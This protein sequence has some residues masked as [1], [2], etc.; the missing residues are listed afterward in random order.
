MSE[1]VEEDE[2]NVCESCGTDYLVNLRVPDCVW[3][4][5]KPEDHPPGEGLLCGGC[6]MDRIESL[7]GKSTWVLTQL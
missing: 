3:E 4:K 2:G 7:L 1:T 6:I 5:I